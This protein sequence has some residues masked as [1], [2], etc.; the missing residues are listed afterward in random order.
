MD[1]FKALFL[2]VLQGMTELFPVSSLGHTVVIPGA[3]GWGDLLDSPAFLPLVVTL[4]LGMAAALLIFFWRDWLAIIR[5]FFNTLGKRKIG[6]DP[7]ERLAWLIVVGTI[8]AGLI[9][10]IFEQP[11]TSLF[12][13]PELAA[14]FL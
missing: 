9:G 2:A 14:V 11:L 6:E 8:P 3:L 1:W 13:I 4:H 12:S 10:L 5:A 7:D